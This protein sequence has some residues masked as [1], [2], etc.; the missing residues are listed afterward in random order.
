MSTRNIVWTWN[1]IPDIIDQWQR[2]RAATKI[3]MRLLQQSLDFVT[4]FTE[5]SR[6]FSNY[7]YLCQGSLKIEKNIFAPADFSTCLYMD[8]EYSTTSNIICK[9]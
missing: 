7:F 5:E 9:V 6:N 4:V 1:S 2:R 8:V 3:L